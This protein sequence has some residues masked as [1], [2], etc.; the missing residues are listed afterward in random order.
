MSDKNFHFILG[1]I[2]AMITAVL[3][4]SCAEPLSATYSDCERGSSEFC[5]LY[6]KVVE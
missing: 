2:T 3:A 5:P 1:F 6:V 4:L